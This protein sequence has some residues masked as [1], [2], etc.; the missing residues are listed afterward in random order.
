MQGEQPAHFAYLSEEQLADALSAQSIENNMMSKHSTPTRDA[1]LVLWT[2]WL[3]DE[4]RAVW[5]RALQVYVRICTALAMLKW[6]KAKLPPF[7]AELSFP[8]LS[9]N[10]RTLLTY[11]N[12]YNVQ[13][14]RLILLP[15][16]FDADNL[17]I[18]TGATMDDH[19]LAGLLP[20]NAIMSLRPLMKLKDSDKRGKCARKY[21]QRTLEQV[22]T[23]CGDSQCP[24]I[25]AALTEALEARSHQPQSSSGPLRRKQPKPQ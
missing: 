18:P 24:L 3:T 25:A 11:W 23:F 19:P 22:A 1:T 8:E 17:N 7:M 12:N 4:T 14:A 6:A 13:A 20:S 16:F 15:A 5:K 9:A 10:A 21:T 2:Y